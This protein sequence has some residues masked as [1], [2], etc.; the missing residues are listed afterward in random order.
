MDE[1]D[2]PK[3]KSESVK[4]VDKALDQAYE[5]QMCTPAVVRSDGDSSSDE[6][7][8]TETR[9]RLI[10]S[11]AIDS[12]DSIGTQPTRKVSV[13]S[14]SSESSIEV[15]KEISSSN[16]VSQNLLQK[17]QLREVILFHSW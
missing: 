10:K 8:M 3:R 13:T 16:T 17:L 9:P 15:P 1:I 2:A 7:S 14:T 12:L 4:N 5:V 11:S 6:E